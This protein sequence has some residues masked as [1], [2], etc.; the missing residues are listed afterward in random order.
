MTT[1]VLPRRARQVPPGA[2]TLANAPV[3][4][5]LTSNG[6]PGAALFLMANSH[7]DHDWEFPL[8]RHEGLEVLTLVVAGSVSHYDTATGHWAHLSPGD[9]QL[10]NSGSGISHIERATAGTHAFQIQFDPGFDTT[11]NEAPGYTDYRASTFTPRRHEGATITDLVGAEAPISARTEGL[12]V[13]RVALRAGARA[14]LPTSPDRFTLAYTITGETRVNGARTASDDAT[15]TTGEDQLRLAA[16]TDSDLL[17][18]DLPPTPATS[19]VRGIPHDS[20]KGSRP[21]CPHT[22]SPKPVPFTRQRFVRQDGPSAQH[23]PGPSMHER[24][25]RRWIR[26]AGCV[27]AADRRGLQRQ[28]RPEPDT[29]P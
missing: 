10:M 29:L 8:H 18:I 20:G 21:E 17:V 11:I 13:Q 19:P 6:G 15:T 4:G 28:G 27:R 2:D 25:L 26:L 7:V 22:D 14:T 3:A 12:A 1:T 16:E 5:G 9:L 24:R 23:L